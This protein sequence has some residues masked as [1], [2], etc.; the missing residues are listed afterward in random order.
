M[1]RV[2]FKTVRT[3]KL[4]VAYEER[5]PADGPPVLLLH[6]FPDDARCWDA[7]ATALASAGRRTLAPYAR[8]F[9]PTRFLRAETPRDGQF[10]ALGADAVDFAD[11]LDLR[12][13][14]V[15]GQDWGS[16]TAE[17]LCALR[18]DRVTRLVKLNHY[19][20]YSMAEMAAG[21]VA[22]APNYDQLHA[23]WYVWLLNLDTGRMLLDN[24]R[25]GFARSLWA[26]WSPT[27]SVGE[28]DAAFDAVA[29]S[30]DNPDF[31]EVVLSAYRHG[32]TEPEGRDARYADLAKRLQDPPPVKA[33][34][35][36][37]NGADDGVEK[38]PL[39][40]AGE[41]KYFAG[42]LTRAELSGVGHFPQ[43]ERPQAVIDAVL[44]EQA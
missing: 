32:L 15:V 33:P 25:R 11:A 4:E 31:V 7:V 12:N 18:P 26:A 5:G 8:G 3:P 44:G 23:L 16:P 37:L 24:D 34:T 22:G 19:G 1:T 20:V 2:A 35:V 13:L 9:G 41:R 40:A 27:W 21:F 39:S 28:M 30:F 6:G 17:I 29:D 10:A 14:T 38:T 43:R 36:L 42:G